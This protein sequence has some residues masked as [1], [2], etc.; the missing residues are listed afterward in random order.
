M[1]LQVLSLIAN[2]EVRRILVLYHKKSKRNLKSSNVLFDK[3]AVIGNF[4]L[5]KAY[6]RYRQ[7]ACNC[8]RKFEF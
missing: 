2:K 3:S 6:F 5:I 1:G 8:K 7:N 4:D